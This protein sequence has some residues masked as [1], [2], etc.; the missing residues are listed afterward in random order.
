MLG[1][2]RTVGAALVNAVI[3][4]IGAAVTVRVLGLI[5]DPQS[6][7]PGWLSLV[8][9]P[10]FSFVMWA[11]LKP[12]RRLTAMVSPHVDPLGEGMGSFGRTARRSKRWLKQAGVMAAGT[13][14]GNVAAATAVNA[15]GADEATGDAGP[16]APAPGRAESRPAAT[17]PEPMAILS[18][19]PNQ[20]VL[21][22]LPPAVHVQ[23]RDASDSP[24]GESDPEESRP[25]THRHYDTSD[26]EPL[27]P[28]E[29]EWVDGE[30]VY[31]VCRPSE[32]ANVA[33]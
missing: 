18:P 6:R 24:G 2:G 22:A 8:L 32:D 26:A 4:G 17:Y 30:E 11:A 5:L 23:H 9:M 31:N 12:F 1:I 19:G 21:A 13:A 29:P 14:T 25:S 16:R 27:P 20:P 33:A 7:L 28:I 10:L 3:F 15:M